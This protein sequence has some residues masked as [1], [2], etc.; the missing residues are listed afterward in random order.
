MNDMQ[1]GRN[2]GEGQSVV[3]RCGATNCRYNEQENCT[4]GQIEVDFSGQMAQCLTF[5]PQDGQSDSARMGEG[6]R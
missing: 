3:S 4:A 6:T 1:Q 5:S 2:M